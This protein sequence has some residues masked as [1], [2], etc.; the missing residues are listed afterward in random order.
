M[1]RSAAAEWIKARA[2]IAGFDLAGIAALGPAPTG[3]AYR[4]WLERGDQG[5]MTWMERHRDLRLDPRGLLEGA[6]SALVVGLRYAPLAGGAE[7]P[8]GDLWPRVARYA[9]GDDYHDLMRERLRGVAG[10]VERRWPGTGT[11][12]AVD[13]APLLERDL[14]A[15]AG[16]GAIGKNTNL[17]HPEAGSWFLI[18][19]LLTTLDL[20]PDRPVADLCG[21]CSRC[22]EA[23]PTGALP[24]PWR[25]DAR[26]CISYWTIEHRGEI[27]PAIRPQLADRVF[28][29]DICQEVCPWNRDPEPAAHPELAVPARRLGLDLVGLLALPEPGYREAFR[30][31]PMKRAK[32]EGL[33]RNAAL[34]LA[35]REDPPA[36]AA[37]ERAERG[38]PSPVVRAAASWARRRGSRAV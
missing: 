27:A 30:G 4:R 31:S 29:C 2:R 34:A 32:S 5:G 38:D 25:L 16:L 26:R 17:I 7:T 33:R 20:A 24:E 36:R 8:P 21:E 11:R 1:D 22:L 37:L 18:A 35:G 23:C 9:R 12:I 6:C 10:E 14:A 15:R 3:P 13:T 19:E 28:G